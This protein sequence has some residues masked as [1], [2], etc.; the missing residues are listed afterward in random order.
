MLIS[1]AAERFFDHDAGFAPQ[2]WVHD[3]GNGVLQDLIRGAEAR[4][5][6]ADLWRQPGFYGCSTPGIDFMVD[7]AGQVPGVLGAQLAGAGLGG[8]VMVLVERSGLPALQEHLQA[9]YYEP[10]SI[11]PLMIP[12]RPVRGCGCLEP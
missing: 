9:T 6:A 3:V 7:A 12:C 1:H 10:R 11:E 5:P 8:C 2:A 4:D